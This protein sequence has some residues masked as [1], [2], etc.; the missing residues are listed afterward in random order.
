VASTFPQSEEEAINK[1]QQYNLI[2]AYSK[3]LYMVLP[4]ALR[5]VPF[6]QDKP[7]MS[8]SADG[9][10]GT[11][12]HHNPY[13]QPPPMYGT[14]QYLPIYGGPS[15]YPPP[16]YQQSYPVVP[17]QSLGAPPLVPMLY[18][19]SQSSMGPPQP[20]DIT[21]PVV[22]VPLIP[23]RHMDPIHR[24]IHISHFLVL[25]SWLILHRDN[26]MSTSTLFIPFPFNRFIH[27]NN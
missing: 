7:G 19:V 1:A 21:V 18:P 12:T 4:D 17:P 14:P 23:I 25:P 16:L 26:H 5:P 3:Y 24:T 11:T 6:N 2:Y 27:L 9:L 13:I 20:L 15:Y 10:I 8:H 22:E